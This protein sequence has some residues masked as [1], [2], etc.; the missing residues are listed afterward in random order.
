MFTTGPTDPVATAFESQRDEAGARP[1]IA[2]R[3][4]R[5]DPTG[6]NTVARACNAGLLGGLQAPR[7]SGLPSSPTGLRSSSGMAG[8]SCHAAAMGEEHTSGMLRRGSGPTRIQPTG[9]SDAQPVGTA[10]R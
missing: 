4:A 7:T 2:R 6:L 10:S 8:E 1:V 5:R 9:Q 3:R